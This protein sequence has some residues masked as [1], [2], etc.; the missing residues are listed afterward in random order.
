METIAPF[1]SEEQRDQL[2]E[3]LNLDEPLPVRYSEWLTG[4]VQG[5]MG[6]YYSVSSNR[7]VADRVAAWSG[8]LIA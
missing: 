8:R 6:S 5:D 1:A 7:P 2:R 3:D 4:F